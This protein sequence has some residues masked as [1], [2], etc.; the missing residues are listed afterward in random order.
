ML[1]RFAGHPYFVKVHVA[2]FALWI[3][4]NSGMIALFRPSWLP[5]S[6]LIAQNRENS[7]AEMRA[8]LDYEV[9][10]RSYRKLVDLEKRLDALIKDAGNP[11]N[12]RHAE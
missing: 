10:I 7:Y 6:I 9:N 11:G 8:E 12:E 5:V 4:I 1:S 3:L 2:W